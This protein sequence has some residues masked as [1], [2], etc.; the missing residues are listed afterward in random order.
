[1]KVI[2]LRLGHR[3]FRDKRLTTHVA[4]TAR[5]FGA[6]EVVISGEKD[7]GILKSIEDICDRWGGNFKVNYDKN[8]KS[9]LFNHKEE[10]WELI[11][12]TMYGSP[13]QEH[14]SEIRKSS[15]NKII[16]VGSEKV[17]TEVYHMAN[18]NLSVT[19]QPHSEAAALGVFLH[20]FFEGNELNKE[21]KNPK[22]K[23]NPNAKGKDVK[24]FN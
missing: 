17:P 24:K 15:K 13:Y 21:F 22:L 23:I 8:W 18:Y 3:I 2:V 1:M 12:L 14:I 6:D 19:N 10:G 9:F 16:I 7:E 4:L 5:A 11:H 20:D